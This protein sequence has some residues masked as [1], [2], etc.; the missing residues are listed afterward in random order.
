MKAKFLILLAIMQ[1]LLLCSCGKK[2]YIYPDDF[3]FRLNFEV[4]GKNQIDTYNGT[5]TK[6][7]IIDGTKTI[8]FIVPE[9]IKKEIFNKMT[10]IGIMS[11]PDTLNLDDLY[12]SPS[13]DYD[14]H[15]T[16]NGTVKA[17]VWT[18]GFYPYRYED[19]PE[20]NKEF[21]GLVKYISDYIYGTDEYKQM[22]EA[23]GGY[24]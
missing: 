5:F 20:K 14:L 11:F 13:C 2:E 24:D 16:V 12:I 18:D 9:N 7:L 17:V 1:L 23:N 15:I 6:D 10:E 3:N 8:D 19:L 22:P 21:L 4:D